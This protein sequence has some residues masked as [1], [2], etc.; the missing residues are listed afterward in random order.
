[1][2]VTDKTKDRLEEQLQAI[3]DHCKEHGI[4]K[5]IS[6]AWPGNST[7]LAAFP[8][9]EKHGIRF[10]RRGCLHALSCGRE[11]SCGRVA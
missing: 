11:V 3:D 9:L 6:F 2:G 5:P 4:P 1:M 8:I 10:A 7:T